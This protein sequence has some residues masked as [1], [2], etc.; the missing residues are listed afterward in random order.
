MD[1][2]KAIE[3]LNLKH[4]ATSQN[5]LDLA[6]EEKRIIQFYEPDKNLIVYG[7]LAPNCSNHSKVEH[8]SGQWCKVLIRGQLEKIG[9][10]ADLGY[11]GYRK[12]NSALDKPINASVLIS[13]ELPAHF[14][15]LDD[16]EGI[17]YE[18]VL[19][20][21]ELDTGEIGVGNIYALKE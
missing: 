2:N 9:W 6:E 18:R 17:E 12:T 15:A 3:G 8:I 19:A 11:W 5:N 14:D 10:G 7:S 4:Y 13:D 1:L 21:F 16:F 20:I